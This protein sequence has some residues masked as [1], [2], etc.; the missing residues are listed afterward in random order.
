VNNDEST[1][2][3]A[4]QGLLISL[5]RKFAARYG[6]DTDDAVQ[7]GGIGLLRAIR[8]YEPERGVPFLA[9]ARQRIAFAL[10]DGLRIER[11]EASRRSAHRS[12]SFVSIDAPVCR[13]GSSTAP[14]DSVTLA[15]VLPEFR[16]EPDVDDGEADRSSRELRAAIA[17]LPETWRRVIEL[18]YY[19][20]ME[21]ADIA[22]EMFL[23]PSRVSQLLTQA[24]NRIRETLIDGGGRKSQ[25]RAA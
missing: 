22:R 2:Y 24:R 23:S 3:E 18:Y 16:V 5:A 6:S 11:I 10:L 25:R 15:D 19:E 8:T 13:N 12:I 14:A 17:D 20:D 4:H 9:W 7:S 21:Q 1:Q